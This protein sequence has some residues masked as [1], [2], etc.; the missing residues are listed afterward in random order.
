MSKTSANFEIFVTA[1]VG[2]SSRGNMICEKVMTFLLGDIY[3]TLALA[4]PLT[5]RISQPW[6]F[7]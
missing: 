2:M 3:E 7:P 4:S 6:M 5:S 1:E